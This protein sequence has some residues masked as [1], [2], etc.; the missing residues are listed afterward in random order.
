[1][2]DPD[3]FVAEL[4]ACDGAA[5]FG[6]LAHLVLGVLLETRAAASITAGQGRGSQSFQ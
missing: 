2:R 5:A 4:G 1:V 6:F 3:V